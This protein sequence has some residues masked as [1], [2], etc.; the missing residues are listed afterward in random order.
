VSGPPYTMTIVLPEGG[1]ILGAGLNC[2]AGG[3]RCSVVMPGAMRLGLEAEPSAGY[4]FGG[5]TGDC[6]G[7]SPAFL[8]S[9]NGPRTCGATFVAR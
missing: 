9:L 4:T 8:I 7:S 2:G 3:T 5:W 1:R 6:S